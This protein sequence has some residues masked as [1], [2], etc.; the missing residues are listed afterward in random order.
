[1]EILGGD[2][3]WR[4][5]TVTLDSLLQEGAVDEVFNQQPIIDWPVNEPAG[6]RTLFVI[7]RPVLQRLIDGRT[8]GLALTPLGPIDASFRCRGADAPRLLFN[9][10]Q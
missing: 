1:V 7:S 10:E 9:L 6:G 5:D 2:P 3:A 4:R 8:L